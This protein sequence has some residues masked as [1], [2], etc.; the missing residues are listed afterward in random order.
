MHYNDNNHNV[1]FRGESILFLAAITLERLG[2][3]IKRLL[4][5]GSQTGD[6]LLCPLERRLTII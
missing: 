6:A 4:T 1:C 5:F 3:V 2:L